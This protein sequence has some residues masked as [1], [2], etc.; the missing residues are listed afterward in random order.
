MEK[1]ETYE[2]KL[3][4]SELHVTH[5]I[6][7]NEHHCDSGPGA[8]SSRIV[9]CVSGSAS[10]N[11]SNGS[12][13]IDTGE[14]FFIPEGAQYHVVWSGVPDIEYYIFHIHALVFDTENRDRF[15]IQ[16][17]VGVDYINAYQTY[18]N[19]YA[20][21]SS[22]DRISK[23]RAVGLYYAFYAEILPCLQNEPPKRYH[24]A[25]IAAMDYISKHYAEDFPM[26]ALAV[27]TCVS[28]SRLFHLFREALGTTPVKYRNEI[29]VRYAC[30]M[31]RAGD[32]S[33]DEVASRNGF[34]TTAYFREIFKKVTG[35]SPSEFRAMTDKGSDV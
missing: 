30:A 12:L 1:R 16:K 33:L 8:D 23:I 5:A 19:V 31:I 32:V 26:E 28:E 34:H 17:I 11:T 9:L 15:P 29:R 25:V 24:A 4:M 2:K 35:I 21:M 7:E 10:I 20:L 6:Y 27:A 18:T 22:G 14:L 13:H 3:C